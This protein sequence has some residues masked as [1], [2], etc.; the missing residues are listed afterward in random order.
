[1]SL[2]PPPNFLIVGPP[3]SG[4]TSLAGYMEQHPEV[5]VCLYKEN[6]Y[7]AR[8]CEGLPP[9]SSGSWEEYLKHFEA[10]A[11]K[12]VRMEAAT[13][14][15][16]SQGAPALIKEK[17]PDVKLVTILRD[18]ASRAYSM[19]NYKRF[20]RSLPPYEDIKSF[21]KALDAEPARLAAK[22]TL[23]FNYVDVSRYADGIERFRKHFGE[24]QFRVLF[25]EDLTSKPEEVTREMFEWLGLDSTVPI[26]VGERRNEGVAIK[27]ESVRKAVLEG[28]T[29]K[30]IVK[31]AIP[32]KLRKHAR[33][34]VTEMFTGKPDVLKPEDRQRVI[35]A[36]RDDI[37]R[38]QELTGRDLS[39]WLKV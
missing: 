5:S 25:F 27:N 15:L 9:W 30:N 33:K 3:K 14:Y 20:K 34:R 6:N 7:F 35:D 26:Q 32:P 11:D 39:H 4:T 21:S 24:D 18:P 31:L 29:L 8:A 17:V 1:M 16:Y 28:S 37:L 36:C 38:V 2:P 10:G 19:Y 23:D 13:W 12:A 22:E